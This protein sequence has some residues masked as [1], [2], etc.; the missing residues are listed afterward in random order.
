[1]IINRESKAL[2]V[3]A[4]HAIDY[5][6]RLEL[7]ET[8]CMYSHADGGEAYLEPSAIFPV[9]QGDIDLLF[10][11]LTNNHVKRHQKQYRQFLAKIG[12]EPF[13]R[14]SILD[15]DLKRNGRL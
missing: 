3:E 5:G 2:T 7:L 6:R 14:E 12:H 10:V 9:V 1:M 4:I 11:S 15:E 13:W 8:A